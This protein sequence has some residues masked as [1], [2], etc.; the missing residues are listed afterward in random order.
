[1]ADFVI[2]KATMM[3]GFGLKGDLGERETLKKID[4]IFLDFLKKHDLFP[5]HRSAH[6]DPGQYSDFLIQIAPYFDDFIAKLFNIEEQVSILR[7]KAAEFDII[8]ECKRK[9]VERIALKKYPTA[10]VSQSQFQEAKALLTSELGQNFSNKVFAENI[11]AQKNEAL[12]EAAC[13]YAS[14]ITANRHPELDSGSKKSNNEVPNRVRD[15]N[16]S[17][18]DSVLFTVPQKIDQN[19]LLTS[20]LVN[21]CQKEVRFDFDNQTKFDSK[22]ALN[23]AKYCIYC[24]KQN[25]DSCS[26]GL[27]YQKIGCPLKQKI[28]EMNYVASKGFYLAA[29]A[30]IIIDNPMV[31]ATGHRICND[32]SKSC[33]FQ[34][35]EPV[36][37]PY[38]ESDIFQTVLNLPWGLEIYSLLTRWNPLNLISIL[39]KGRTSYNI[40]IVGLGPAGFGLAHYLLNSGHNVVA[41]DGLKINPIN[42]DFYKPIKYWNEH[43]QSLKD[44]IPQGFGG[45]AEYGITSRWDKNNLDIIRIIIERYKNFKIYDSVRF[46]GNITQDQAFSLGFDH[47]AI[48][49]GAGAPKFLGPN[50]LAK[51]VRTA[52][53]FLMSLQAGGAFLPKSNTNLV[54]RLP[55]AVIGGGLTAVDAAVEA[56]NYY[57]MQ[58][59]KFLKLYEDLEQAPSWGHEDKIIADEFIAHAKLFRGK[60]AQEVRDII[61]QDLGGVS[62]YYHRDLKDSAAYRLNHEEIAHA[63]AAGVQFIPNANLLKIEQDEY[64]YMKELEFVGFRAQAKTMLVAVGVDHTSRHPDLTYGSNSYF[65]DA[66]PNYSGSVVKALASAKYGHGAI[67]SRLLQTEPKFTGS[68]AE[69]ITKLDYLLTSRIKRISRLN[70]KIIEIVITSPLAAQNFKP[71]QFFKLQNYSLDPANI[72]EPLSLTGMISDEENIS[73]LIE[74]LGVSSGLCENFVEN[75][76][77]ALMGPGGTTKGHCERAIASAAIHKIGAKT[78]CR[79]C[80]K[81]PPRNDAILL[82]GT[83]IK[84]ILLSSLAPGLRGNNCKIIH[85]AHYED[86][87]D[88]IYR[89]KIEQASNHVI[90]SMNILTDLEYVTKNFSITNVICSTSIANSVLIKKKLHGVANISHM[91]NTPMQCMM[92]GVCGQCVISSN[93][94]YIFS[95]KYCMLDDSINL[96][97]IQNRLSQNSIQET[98]GKFNLKKM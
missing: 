94:D 7:A 71:G 37:I 97:E 44:R 54:M 29:L 9:F 5:Q 47:I 36:D 70:N 1:V 64:G 41:I 57:P 93:N 45:V 60:S 46:G 27:D 63:L 81:E 28:S 88:V 12:I 74:K 21:K 42:F 52:A 84:N 98:L 38:V 39:P 48:C 50:F 11:L 26:K 15:D 85:L 96:H 89:E 31:A 83:G 73:F 20:H 90:W 22:K 87:G 59:A 34:K 3:L 58:V 55:V 68:Y 32:C 91:T 77:I 62:I 82:I 69:L 65:G 17:S 23:D 95:C 61:I 78:D 4:Q 40:L 86:V 10:S 53:E 30:I 43:K 80:S 79:V 35:Q 92:Q 19:N 51:G 75:E 14:Y 2:L 72:M 13:V 66:N 49:T 33:I 24:H 16:G 25:K 56:L 6:F 18:A 76:K 8:Y 67:T